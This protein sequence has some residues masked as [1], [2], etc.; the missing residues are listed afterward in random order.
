MRGERRPGVALGALLGALGA[1]A[2]ACGSGG[3]DGVETVTGI[4]AS[5]EP[6]FGNLPF[7][8]PVKLVQHPDDDDRWYVVEQGGKIWTFLASSPVKAMAADVPNQKSIDLGVGERGLLGMAFDPSFAGSGEVYLAYTDGTLETC[9]LERW[10]S[11]DGGETFDPDEVL[12]TVPHPGQS[13]HNGG[14]LEFGPDGF[15]YWTVG[16][17]GGSNDP[18]GNGQN[19]MTLLGSILRL[20]VNG[21]PPAGKTYAIPPGN[22][23]PAGNPQC[24]TGSG[25]MPCP[26]I[27]AYG[28]RNPWRIQFD[29]V[30]DD[31]W[32]GDVGQ[33]TQEEVDLVEVG[34]NY[35]W[36]CF[37]GTLRMRSNGPCAVPDSTFAPPEAVHGRSEAQAITGGAVYRGGAIPSLDGFYVYG[38]FVTGRFFTFDTAN[39]A[40]PVQNLLIPKASVTDFGQ[41]RDGEVY[42][43]SFGSPSIQRLAPP[44][45]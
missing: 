32:T 39:L 30:T 2:A 22:A 13:N 25:A 3:G 28:F 5:L 18:N 43:V 24:D 10:V 17:G 8:N 12:L 6:A 37:E 33:A 31:L 21:A 45:P 27:F 9:V 20:D 44:A 34:K 11:A 19:P 15:L 41:G 40:A 36:N 38:D 42:V 29:P 14:D 23:F 26:E 4:P 16:D 1:L 7:A 35:G